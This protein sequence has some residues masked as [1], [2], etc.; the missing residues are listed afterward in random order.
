MAS[1]AA[2]AAMSRMITTPTRIARALDWQKLS[3]SVLSVH[4]G[5]TSIDLAVTF[6]PSSGN[7]IQALPSI[8]I[9]LETRD[10]SKVLKS[11]VLQELSDAVETWNACGLVVSWPV[12]REGWC[13]K[14][15]GRTLHF[16]DQIAQ[17]TNIV[18]PK[19]PLALWDGHHFYNTED[20]WG[21]SS[22][23]ATTSDRSVHVASKEQYR[24]EGMLAADIAADYL[25]FHFPDLVQNLQ[26]RS[27]RDFTSLTQDSDVSESFKNAHT[28]QST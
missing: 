24:D 7:P 16:L 15:C 19:R 28:M 9:E 25:R 27:S 22:I 21:R 3:S 18:S 23:Y 6:H 13:G 8:P 26:I 2:S 20:S 4:V 17:D 12:Q 14:P 10:N 1:A 11:S 5:E